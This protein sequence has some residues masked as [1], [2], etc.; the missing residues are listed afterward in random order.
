MLL[1]VSDSDPERSDESV[2]SVSHRLL[3]TLNV[4]DG[5]SYTSAQK[6]FKLYIP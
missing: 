3:F 5:C 4:V 6:L 1:S 2:N